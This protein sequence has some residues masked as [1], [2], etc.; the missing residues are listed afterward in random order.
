MTSVT[1]DWMPC[2]IDTSDL[3]LSGEKLREQW[4][5]LHRGNKEPFPESEQVQDAWRQYH[6]GNFARAVEIGA[7]AGGQ[8]V[9]PAAFA[10][11]IYAQYIERDEK[12]KIEL[13][14]QAMALCKDAEAGGLSTPNL[15]YMHAVAMGRYSQFISMIEALAQG[16]GGRIKE[17]VEKCLELVPDH[18][19]AHATFAG[20]HAGISDQAGALMGRMLYGA[21]QDGAHEHYDEAV[22]LAPDSVVPQ[23]EYARGLQVMYGD[24]ERASIV[25][26][27]EKAML[28]TP[29]DAMQRLDQEAARK[30]LAAIK[31]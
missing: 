27:L 29:V 19:E 9:V 14:K 13:F 3:D 6:L 26:K 25:E 1:S 21:T 7:E 5:K 16:F 12:R 30:E 2:P 31:A 10:T 18:A 22:R 8:G 24:S 17:Q 4:D 15:H 23:I 20:W 11:T 28:L